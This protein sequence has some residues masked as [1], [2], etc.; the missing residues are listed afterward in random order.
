[1]EFS[2]S[3]RFTQL[4]FLIFAL[5]MICGYS[6]V[7]FTLIN[8]FRKIHKY[9]HNFKNN[10]YW[11]YYKSRFKNIA[12]VYLIILVFILI[13]CLIYMM[14]IKKE[15]YNKDELTLLCTA[16]TLY[17]SFLSAYLLKHNPV[18]DT[19]DED[20]DK[21]LV[22]FFRGT[23]LLDL[24]KRTLE[25]SNGD[26]TLNHNQREEKNHLLKYINTEL[27]SIMENIK[28]N[29][30]S[31]KIELRFLFDILQINI[32]NYYECINE[33]QISREESLTAFYH[34]FNNLYKV[35]KYFLS[36][37]W[38]KE[39]TDYYNNAFKDIQKIR[40]KCQY[41]NIKTYKEIVEVKKVFKKS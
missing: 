13:L 29:N 26:S 23:L 17:I 36:D 2:D 38:T 14:I 20:I 31:Y 11:L 9:K 4:G 10:E 22:I 40:T 6:V 12:L 16:V 7:L 33:V 32:M 18:L 21:A 25:K 15:V 27:K 3:F 37:K 34:S 30:S 35:Y 5:I 1:M 28:I 8:L 19:T 41:I 39:Y 24:G